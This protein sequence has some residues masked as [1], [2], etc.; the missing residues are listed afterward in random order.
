MICDLMV[1]G[2]SLIIKVTQSIQDT[3]VSDPRS[4]ECKGAFLWENLNPDSCIQK[5]ILHFF[6]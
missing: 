4:P 3:S 5:R 6:T 1:F 2:V